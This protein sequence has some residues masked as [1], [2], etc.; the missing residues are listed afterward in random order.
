ML[1]QTT[2]IRISLAV[3]ATGLASGLGSASQA[4]AHSSCTPQHLVSA[5]AQVEAQ[6]GKARVVSDHRPGA[7]IAGTRHASQHSFCNG[8]NGAIDAVFQNKSCALSA[9]RATNYTILTYRQSPHIH[10]GTDTWSR[11]ARTGGTRTARHGHTR[12]RIAA[13]SRRGDSRRV[14]RHGYTR[15]AHRQGASQSR[16]DWS[17]SW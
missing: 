7:V 2:T 5:L 17:A 12:V 14:A 16:G 6:C 4:H 9:L 11:T 1:K 13:R 10:I 3:I 15:L 8:T